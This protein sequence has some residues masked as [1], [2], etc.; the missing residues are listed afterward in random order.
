MDANFALPAHEFVSACTQESISGHQVAV[1]PVTEH[2]GPAVHTFLWIQQLFPE[3]FRAVVLVGVVKVQAEALGTPE[4][5]WRRQ[6]RLDASLHQLEAYCSKAGLCVTRTVGNG[7]DTIV[8]LERLILATAASFP[9]CVCFSNRLILPVGRR[10]GE[11]LHN[12]TAL[13]LQRR[14]HLQGIPL[15]I[16]PISL[17]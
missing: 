10:F 11:W 9:G 14:L 16:L 17:R 7:I 6:E 15:I 5:I 12:Q 3:Q 8:E 1:L 2:W 13:G 4:A